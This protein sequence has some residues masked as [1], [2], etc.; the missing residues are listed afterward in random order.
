MNKN[1][2][3][4]LAVLLGLFSVSSLSAQTEE[5]K[6]AKPAKPVAGIVGQQAPEWDV[7]EWH[8]LP[9]GKEDLDISDYKGKVLYLY[10]F[11]PGVPV[12]IRAASQI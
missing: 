11:N 7:S 4:C 6:P 9:E 2:F 3:V 8:Q 10:F 1:L 5:A 12:V